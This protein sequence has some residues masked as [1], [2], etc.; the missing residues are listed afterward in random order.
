MIKDYLVGTPDWLIVLAVVAFWVTVLWHVLNAI[1]PFN[2]HQEIG[3]GNV[4]FAAQRCA[5]VA[6][7]VIAMRAT[8]V[9]YD[10][11]DKLSS[12]VWMMIEGLWVFI[13]ILVS[14]YAVDWIVLPGIDNTELIR[15]GNGG[16]AAVEVG[17]YL[18]IGF[19]LAGSL[20]GGAHTFALS[21]LSTVAFYL[22]GLLFVLAI[23]WL[24]ELVTPYNLRDH[25]K[26]G[27]LTAGIEVGSL[28]LAMSVV[29]S[30]GVAGDFTGWAIG[31]Q[32]FLL[33]SVISVVLLYPSRWILNKFGPGQRD[34]DIQNG[35]EHVAAAAVSGTML[36][37]MGFAVAGT[38]SM[39]L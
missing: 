23:F 4:A 28:I 20:T 11:T 18:G 14:R 36:V 21:L 34:R 5:L 12:F 26:Q 13:A 16:V 1:T 22:L 35:T 29:V 6:A 38:V 33:T 24:H 10:S 39:V 30:V 25:L 31:I 32:A 27:S 19:I 2:D 15:Q 9:G 3:R 37:V 7:Q 8:F 17:S